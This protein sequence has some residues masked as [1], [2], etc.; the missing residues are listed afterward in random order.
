MALIQPHDNG[1]NQHNINQITTQ[2]PN[3]TGNSI[4]LSTSQLFPKSKYW[5]LDTGATDH[6]CYSLDNFQCF[7]TIKPVCVKLPDGSHVTATIAGS[8]FFSNSLYLSDVLYIPQFTFNLIS[9]PKLTVALQCQLRFNHVTCEIQDLVTSRTIGVAK[10]RNGLYTLAGQ[11]VQVGSSPHLINFCSS[12]L[13][14]WHCRLGHPSRDRLAVMQKHYPFITCVDNNEPC[15]SCHY[16]KQKRLVF[17]LSN[18]CSSHN[19]DLIHIDIWGPLAA[20]SMLGFRYFLTIVDDKSRFTWLYFMKAKSEASSLIPLF[21]TFVETQFSTRI[22]CIRSDNGPEL[23]LANFFESKGIIHHTSCVET[24]QQNGVVERKHQHLLNVARAILFQSSLPAKFWHF[25]VAHAAHLINR[26]ATP[27]LDNKSPF[28]ILFGSLPNIS[29]FKVF[30]C[31]SFASTLISHRKKLDPR[32]RKCVFLGFKSGTKGYL[33]FDLASKEVF[34]SRNVIFYEH[35]FPYQNHSPPTLSPHTSLPFPDSTLKSDFDPFCYYIH[36]STA[37][38]PS[39]TSASASPTSTASAPPSNSVAPTST[40]LHASASAPFN[41]NLLSPNFACTSSSTSHA[42]PAS[43]L[44]TLSPALPL[45]AS[46]HSPTSENAT[47]ETLPAARRSMRVRKPPTYLQDYHCSLAS[48][49]LAPSSSPRYPI[50]HSLS[51]SSLSP[52]FKRFSL[53]LNTNP[54]P[55]TYQEAIVHDCWKEA[56]NAELTAL[57][58]NGT[59]VLTHLPTGKRAIG[60]KWVFKVKFKADGSIERHKARLVAK[61]YTQTA[62]IDY[63]ETF[64]PVVKI[65]TIRV[66]LSVAAARGWH[67]HQLDVN[68]AFLHGDLHEEVYMEVPPGLDCSPGTVC[69]LQKS[70]Y[71]M[72]QASRQ[73]NAKLTSFLSSCGFIQSKSDYSLFTKQT[74][75]GFTAV[76]VYVDDLVLSGNDLEEIQSIKG[77]LDAKFKIKD[78]GTLR[79]FLGMEVAKSKD[80]ILLYQRK[81]TLDL[82]QDTSMLASKP[83][84]TPMD[85]SLK[86]S[87]DSG[88][89]IVDSTSYR[90]LVGRLLYLSQTRPD[91]SFAVNRLSQFFE[92]PTEVHQQAAYRVLRYLK[93]SPATGL[94]FA[95]ASDLTLKGYSDS[96]WGAC[97]DTRR[98]VTGLCFFLGSSLISWKS[99]KQATVSRSSSEAEYRALSQAA[100][101]AQWLLYLLKDLSVSHPSPVAIFCDNQSALHIAANPVFHERTKHIELDCHFVRDKVQLGIVHL[102]PISSKL[103]VADVLTKPLAPGPFQE[104]HSKLCMKNIH[105]PLAGGC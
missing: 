67:I 29:H 16:A 32:A 20:P 35:V 70:L 62:G 99:K 19:F 8:V 105:A 55:S 39:H 31:L 83:A 34:L 54:E 104:C 91:I 79:Y 14:L 95:A 102:L 10:L 93:G 37:S 65:T 4:I 53:A 18:T 30:G 56:I 15:D 100:C 43:S 13:N 51:Y 69:K 23:R 41:L 25:A 42:S 101:E 97:P 85:H 94:F 76:L 28:E 57:K 45:S 24:P 6:V 82:L 7:K 86:L 68:T 38:T 78:L 17:P 48:S 27:I 58:Q 81:Y 75:R 46:P 12:K 1:P 26:Q 80:G 21:V 72:K 73:W 74:S 47:S 66:L 61:G 22:K 5:I 64:S 3:P 44:S 92:A 33:L 96:D 90:R 87:K 2:P 63:L 40:P 49:T 9:V 98:S 77:L 71:G 84:A 59:W 89:A 52:P 103:Q 88:S 50:S 11:V 60:C 36:A